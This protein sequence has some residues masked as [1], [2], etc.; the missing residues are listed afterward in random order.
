[1][2]TAHPTD[3]GDL[4]A[5]GR[6]S[7]SRLNDITGRA[8]LAVLLL[9]PVPLGSNRPVFWAI[10]AIVLGAILAAYALVLKRKAL[11]LRLPFAQ[12]NVLTFLF[13]GVSLWIAV[14][15]LPLGTLLPLPAVVSVAGYQLE[16]GSISLAPGD[17]LLAM[18]RWLS[19]GVLFFLAV[20]ASVRRQRAR[21]LLWFVLLFVAAQAA[22]AMIA[23]LYLA[24]QVV[25]V[26]KTQY[27]GEAT[28]TFIN[29]NSLATYLGFGAV[30]ALLLAMPD[31]PDT[32]PTRRRLRRTRFDLNMTSENVLAAVALVLI[33]AALLATGSRMGLFATACGLATAGLLRLA[34]WRARLLSLGLL[35]A[36][37][38]LFLFTYGAGTVDRLIMV[39]RDS[40]GRL[41]IY[42][43]TFDMISARPLIGHGA[44]SFEF[45]FPLYDSDPTNSA[46]TFDK[47]HST[48]LTHWSELGLVFGSLPPLIV[49]LIGWTILSAYRASSQR[50]VEL[51]APLGVIVVAAVHST[52]DFSLEIQAVTFLFVTILGI[53]YATAYE[54]AKRTA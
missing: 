43:D 7:T 2:S 23:M 14:Q 13:C 11:K 15:I 10:W 45:A 21:R 53:G 18:L 49:V 9:A 30:V 24:D 44:Q 32:N 37:G 50:P 48:Y 39:E 36:G 47:A 34:T 33:L 12:L 22:Y 40:E 25:L 5:S 31:E 42:S 35:A 3:T 46:Y 54:L 8:V 26:E 52:V 1:M 51:C 28:G 4:R 38:L 41:S 20:Q 6:S 17:G 27:L 29:R 16:F 19:Y